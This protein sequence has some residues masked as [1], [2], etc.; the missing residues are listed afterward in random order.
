MDS[1]MFPSAILALALLAGLA[2]PVHALDLPRSNPVPGGIAHIPLGAA[3]DPPPRA[4]YDKRRVA[5]VK[6]EAGWTAVVGIPLSAQP[7]KQRIQVRLANRRE[8]SLTFHV[9]DKAYPAQ[10]I[11][12]KNNR[13]VNPNQKDLK[14][15]AQERKRIQG[16]LDRWS[17]AETPAFTFD[18]PVKGRFSSGF[19]LKRFFNE[20]PR[21][22]HNGLD[23]AAPA[24]T[25]I[26]APAN[27]RVIDAGRFFFSGNLVFLD[28]GQ[29]LISTYAHM[30]SIE[31]EPGQEVQRGERI[32]TV[33]QT[34]RVT[35]PHLHWS[36]NLNR[37]KV[38]PSL[39]LPEGSVPGG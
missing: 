30:Q 21:N 20:Q 35:G 28:H 10:H 37:V 5:V 18:L 11:T 39:F 15:I 16:A 9:R 36:V 33:G 24:G 31:V 34:G 13:M 1:P 8:H 7:G 14:R 25:P 23:I 17:D 22:P 4:H 26:H 27:G 12:I 2:K 19:G 38:D 6:T 29:G 3:D 32:G